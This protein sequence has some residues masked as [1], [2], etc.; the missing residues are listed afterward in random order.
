MPKCDNTQIARYKTA[1]DWCD[2]RDEFNLPKNP[3]PEIWVRAFDEYFYP[4]LETRYFHPIEAIKCIDKSEGEGF[5]I[6]AI[7]CTLIEFLESTAQGI[8][9]RHLKRGEQK[10]DLLPYEYSSSE[11]TF[12]SFLTNRHPFCNHFDLASATTFYEDIRCGLL[13]EARTK[14]GWKIWEKS[15]NQSIIDPRKVIYRNDFQRAIEEFIAWYQNELQH[16][17][18]LQAAFVRKFDHLCE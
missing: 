4:R 16:N 17:P 12:K 7:L 6:L 1:R 11:D 15:G 5:S 13:H 3:C 2:F 18:L 9:Y 8:K 14:N 10:K